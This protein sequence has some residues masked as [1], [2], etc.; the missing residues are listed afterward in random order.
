[1]YGIYV[2]SSFHLDELSYHKASDFT[3]KVSSK[4]FVFSYQI[5]PKEFTLILAQIFGL[6]KNL[7]S[8]E[9][10]NIKY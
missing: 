2:D 3:Q 9:I 7:V 1:M 5:S 8:F 4:Q 10:L 6:P